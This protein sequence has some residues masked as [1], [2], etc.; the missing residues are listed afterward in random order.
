[1][2]CGDGGFCNGTGDGGLQKLGM[3]FSLIFGGWMQVQ[4]FQVLSGKYDFVAMLSR[5]AL[6]LRLPAAS[7]CGRLKCLRIYGSYWARVIFNGTHCQ[8][9]LTNAS[10]RIPVRMALMALFDCPA[11]VGTLEV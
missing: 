8:A 5:R 3:Y 2:G 6:R 4:N 1:M 11:C 9:V 10:T 7:V